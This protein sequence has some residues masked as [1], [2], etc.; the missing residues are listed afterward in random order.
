MSESFDKL[1]KFWE[2]FNYIKSDNIFMKKECDKLSF[3]NKQLRNTLRTY[4]LTI[5]SAPGVQPRLSLYKY[6]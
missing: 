5:S 3:E 2:Q 4:L 1:D 6:I